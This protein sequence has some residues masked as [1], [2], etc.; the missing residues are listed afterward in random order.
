[1]KTLLMSIIV[2]VAGG[3]L[4]MGQDADETA[5]KPALADK[6]LLDDIKAPPPAETL[7]S[8]KSGLSYDQGN[9]S[10]V[11]LSN[12]IVNTNVPL[13]IISTNQLTTIELE[14]VELHGTLVPAIKKRTFGSVLQLFNPFAPAAYGGNVTPAGR[15]SFDPTTDGPSTVLIG[16]DFKPKPADPDK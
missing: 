4:S 1:M 7:S 8:L 10:E 5:G 11:L 2:V 16:V 6:S 12:L 15:D 9:V 13:Q 14:R 3:I